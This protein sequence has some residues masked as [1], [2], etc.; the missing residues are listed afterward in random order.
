MQTPRAPRENHLGQPIGI[1]VPEWK[2]ATPPDRETMR[3]RTCRIEALRADRHAE[4]LH[5]A[6]VE[7]RDGSNWTYLPYGPFDSAAAYR[8]FA[9]QM[10]DRE[11][12]I[13]YAIVDRA[14]E[15]PVGVAT[16]LR[17]DPPNGSIE[18]GHL[19]YAPALQRTPM[20]TEA[21]YL[22]MRRVF[23]DWGY[24][25]YEWKCDS[26]NAPS[27]AAARRLGFRYEG[28]FFNQ[29][30]MKG[31]NRDTSWLSILD[32]EWPRLREALEGWLD[33]SNFDSTGKQRRAL[34]EL[35]PDSAGVSRI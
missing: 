25:R 11:D 16:Y 22:M 29:I 31:R 14:L 12:V 10:Q 20:S 23:D 33:A 21:M 7:N 17:L 13:A 9:E 24:R 3:G 15:R 19:S 30:V 34:S 4:A 2:G 18:V 8:T 27:V 5:A 28:T 1:A 32:G 35:M 6:Y 26:L